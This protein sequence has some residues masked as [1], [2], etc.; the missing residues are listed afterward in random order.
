[1]RKEFKVKLNG[2][3]SRKDASASFTLRFET[4]DVWGKAKLPVKVTING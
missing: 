2:D 3:A 1:M 4:R